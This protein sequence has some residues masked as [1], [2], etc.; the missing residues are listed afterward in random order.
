MLKEYFQAGSVNKAH[1][2]PYLTPYTKDSI[3]TLE[4][5][6]VSNSDIELFVY[7]ANAGI[8]AWNISD[9]IFEEIPGY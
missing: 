6:L 7:N 3:E 4:T 1:V 9:P 8:I 5:N 2:Y